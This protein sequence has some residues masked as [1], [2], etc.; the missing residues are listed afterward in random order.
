MMSNKS[1]STVIIIFGST[2]R[3][4][5]LT[6]NVQLTEKWLTEALVCVCVCVWYRK[7]SAKNGFKL[8]QEIKNKTLI[9]S[10]TRK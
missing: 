9:N 3:F 10:V 8:N 7:E 4:I 2:E 6:D 5:L 1:D